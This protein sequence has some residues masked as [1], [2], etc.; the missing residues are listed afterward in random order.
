[1]DAASA[2]VLVDLITGHCRLNHHMFKIKLSYHAGCA[3]GAP[4]ETVI[5]LVADCPIYFLERLLYL[6]S[7]KLENNWKTI[8]L[9]RLVRFFRAT[10][11]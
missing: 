4:E 11:D 7:V 9:D 8:K 3:C 10:V 2:K 5:H 1:M 6:G